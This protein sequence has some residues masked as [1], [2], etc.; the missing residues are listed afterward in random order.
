MFILEHWFRQPFAARY[1]AIFRQ[2]SPMAVEPRAKYA[3]SNENESICAIKWL[4]YI[5]SV[6]SKLQET[7]FQTLESTYNENI[8]CQ[9]LLELN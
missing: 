6:N 2:I 5:F 7:L 1:D 8:Y 3:K 4:R 9:T